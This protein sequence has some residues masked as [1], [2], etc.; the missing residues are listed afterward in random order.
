MYIYVF[1]LLYPSSS[2]SHS[3]HVHVLVVVLLVLLQQLELLVL[4]LVTGSNLE[5]PLN[6]GHLPNALAGTF[7]T[8]KLLVIPR[9]ILA[10]VIEGPLDGTLAL[11][12]LESLKV[13]SVG[14]VVGLISQQIVQRKFGKGNALVH[15]I[16]VVGVHGR[17]Q[18]A[19][20]MESL[21]EGK[22]LALVLKDLRSL[23]LEIV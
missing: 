7:G 10:N 2:S 20:E 9:G 1:L 6:L 11:G 5:L 12:I 21:G 14:L 16:E 18:L 19:N 23:V 17:Y 3:S 13:M 8:Q 4:L 22:G 15:C